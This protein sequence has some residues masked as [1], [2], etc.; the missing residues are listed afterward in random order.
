MAKPEMGSG[1]DDAKRLPAE[2]SLRL[3]RS[4]PPE[5]RF[6]EI[7]RRLKKEYPD[8][9]CAL[10]FSNPH[11]MLFATILSAQCTDAMVNKVTADL[12]QKYPTIKDYAEADQEEVEADIKP[13]GFFRQ[14]T[15]SLQG[16]ARKILEEYGGEV[17]DTMEELLTLPG[18]ARKTANIVLGNAFGKSVGI[19]VDT[20][21]R[22]VS[23]RLGLTANHDPD[24]IEQDLMRLVPKKNWF[25]I[26][27]LF[28]DH[29]RAVCKAPVPRCED[30]VLS[31]I[32]PSSRV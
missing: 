5:G 16:S 18:V 6:P 12:F 25:P 31:D 3:T 22:R 32:C 20:H 15:K 23:Q 17:P 21:V 14:K 26:T 29:G 27:Y 9:K 7:Y 11:E 30:C 1:A 10:N 13:T 8:A 28:I 4:D 19:A 24:K 2:R